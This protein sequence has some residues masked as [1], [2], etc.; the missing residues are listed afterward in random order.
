[1]GR[2]ET[3]QASIGIRILLSDL[4]SQINE[5]NVELVR[6][7]LENGFIDDE[8]ALFN[9]VYIETLDAYAMKERASE[10][11]DTAADCKAYLETQLANH[12]TYNES[13]WTGERKHTLEEGSLLTQTLLV[14][15]KILLSTERWGYDRYGTNGTSR[16]MDFDLT[17]D[18]EPYK[19]IQ[20]YS[21]VFMLQQRS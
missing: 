12:G 11:K 15:I 2:C 16:P 21:V 4:V 13:R 14:P 6:S 10:C 18:L 20:H 9:H 1:M 5:T 17:C 19:D 8:N 3:A 7:M